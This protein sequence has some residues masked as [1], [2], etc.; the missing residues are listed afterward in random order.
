MDTVPPEVEKV[1]YTDIAWAVDD[2]AR[3]RMFSRMDHPAFRRPVY[4]P[5]VAN[6]M[7]D[8]EVTAWDISASIWTMF[9]RVS[10]KLGVHGKALQAF[11]NRD[12]D[13]AIH[14]SG[15]GPR[16]RN[17]RGMRAFAWTV[18]A[19]LE[20]GLKNPRKSYLAAIAPFVHAFCSLQFRL[21]IDYPSLF[22]GMQNLLTTIVTIH[23]Q[24]TN[25]PWRLRLAA[26]YFDVWKLPELPLLAEPDFDWP[27][28][29]RDAGMALA[30][31]PNNL[32]STLRQ[33]LVQLTI[34]LARNFG[35]PTHVEYDR[36]GLLL[37]VAEKTD[38]DV[39]LLCRRFRDAVE[40]TFLKNSD[41]TIRSAVLNRCRPDMALNTRSRAVALIANRVDNIQ[42]T[43]IWVELETQAFSLLGH[44]AILDMHALGGELVISIAR[45]DTP[46][47]TVAGGILPWL[48][49]IVDEVSRLSMIQSVNI[50]SCVQYSAVAG[51]SLEHRNSLRAIGRLLALY[52]RAGNE[53]NRL[54]K[55]LTSCTPNSTVQEVL[56]LGSPSVRRGFYDVFVDGDFELA[57]V[58]GQD[59]ADMLAHV[60]GNAVSFVGQGFVT[61]L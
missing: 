44:L 34:G 31:E 10:F 39:S 11:S 20:V 56:F 19:M 46:D 7:N 55:L 6:F 21:S 43:R 58:D 54:G 2:D 42:L 32:F 8:L 25:E 50:G 12:M 37:L 28:L 36:I 41:V 17:T 24:Y 45:P 61:T 27:L 40:W 15:A 22:D 53:G 52:L 49:S 4:H 9:P 14:H 51:D 48:G 59:V 35:A 18:R 23:P 38:I 57:Y 30:V 26:T 16:F 29:L 5:H 13:W 3:S 60:G 47:T 33:Q 1:A